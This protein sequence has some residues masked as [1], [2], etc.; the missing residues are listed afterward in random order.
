MPKNEEFK[1]K[2]KH[3]YQHP[4][5]LDLHLLAAKTLISGTRIKCRVLSAVADWNLNGGYITKAMTG[6]RLYLM[7]GA[8]GLMK[9]QQNNSYVTFR[10][11]WNT[12][13]WVLRQSKPNLMFLHSIRLSDRHLSQST[14]LIHIRVGTV[15][16]FSYMYDKTV[17]FDVIY[18]K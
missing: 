10:R 12:T 15:I 11:F 16:N 13:E 4:W 14:I 1:K 18:I 17:Q 5:T 7:L 8:K 9:W 6:C 3:N 2:K